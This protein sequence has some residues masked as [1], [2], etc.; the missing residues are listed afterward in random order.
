MIEG[1]VRVPIAPVRSEPSDRGEMVTQALFGERISI[2]PVDGTLNWAAIRLHSDGYEGFIDPKLVDTSEAAVAAFDGPI[3]LLDRPLTGIEWEGRTLHLPAGSRIPQAAQ[4]AFTQSDLE[5][6]VDAAML[7][8]GAP[9]LWGGKSILGID[10]SGLT[11]LAGALAGHQIPRDASQ[12]WAAAQN[13]RADWSALQNGD[14]VYFHPE[15]RD[16]V[17]HVGL[18]IATSGGTW[19]VLHASGEVRLDTLTPQ[20]IEREGQLTHFWT[21]ASG[22]AF[23]A[24]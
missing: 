13:H 2:S 3:W 18:A 20:G 4:A 15:G 10:C 22:W 11:Q 17:T 21:G 16:A 8:M 7:F 19:Q 24:E 14:L 6:V 9:Y 23:S 5:D 12:Q 1:V